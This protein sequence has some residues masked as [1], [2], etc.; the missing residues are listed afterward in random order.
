MVEDGWNPPVFSAVSSSSVTF[1]P[2]ATGQVAAAGRPVAGATVQ[3]FYGADPNNLPATPSQEV[4]TREDGSYAFRSDQP[5]SPGSP[6][7]FV[8]RLI[9]PAGYKLDAPAAAAATYTGGRPA[10]INYELTPSASIVGTVAAR[11]SAAP[12]AGATVF[13]DLDGDG[14]LDPGE[15]WTRSDSRG[16]YGFLNLEPGS[17]RVAIQTPGGYGASTPTLR[18]V[19]VAD[20]WHRVSDVDFTFQGLDA[21]PAS[22]TP[23]YPAGGRTV[24]PLV[25]NSLSGTA[26]SPRGASAV[27]GVLVSVQDL[28]TGLYWNGFHFIASASPIQLTAEGT[29][30]WRLRLPASALISGHSYRVGSLALDVDGYDQAAPAYQ[31]FTY[32][33]PAALAP[34]TLAATATLATSQ[35]ASVVGQPVGFTVIVSAANPGDGVPTGTVWL[36]DGS[37]LLAAAPLVNGRASF[38]LAG[39]AP[40]VRSIQAYYAGDARFLADFSPTVLQEVARAAIEPGPPTTS[41]RPRPSPS[42][43][44]VG[45][46]AAGEVLQILVRPAQRGRFVQVQVV[47]AGTGVIYDASFP[48]RS[49]RG[50][51]LFDGPG[52]ESVRLMGRLPI[53]VWFSRDGSLSRVAPSPTRGPAPF[54]GRSPRFAAGR[55]APNRAR[56]PATPPQR[57]RIRLQASE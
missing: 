28:D 15:L 49:L 31:T 41:P 33:G 38:Q 40:G 12:L 39:L 1:D 17:Y 18:A 26:S 29:I 6:L 36:L 57:P 23:V 5:A 46:A 16:R 55:I 2:V 9:V 20:A 34:A 22:S 54:R 53:P 50:I 37:T 10:S 30:S 32:Q 48:S 45:G 47:Q 56:F 51:V 43:L 25:T 52:E 14:R 44:D 13:L 35:P 24:G 11:G 3:I 8:I 19:T 42:V 4:V 7:S 27:K 21:S